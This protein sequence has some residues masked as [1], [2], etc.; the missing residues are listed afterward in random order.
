M[1]WALVIEFIDPSRKTKVQLGTVMAEIAGI[2]KR[3]VG[4]I[5]T[6]VHGCAHI[7]AKTR[8]GSRGATHIS[9]H[10]SIAKNYRQMIVPM[11]LNKATR[12]A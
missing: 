5:S 12:Q 9:K 7:F 8:A 4:K 10:I 2:N 3:K 1:A 6:F 11:G